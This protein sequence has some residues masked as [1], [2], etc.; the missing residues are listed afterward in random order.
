[1]RFSQPRATKQTLGIPDRLYLCPRRGLAFWG[2]LKRVGGKATPQQTALHDDLRACG[3][4]VVVGP[5][6]VQ[7]AEMERIVTMRAEGAK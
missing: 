4:T 6:S 7:I 1:V 2:E 5:A 3:M